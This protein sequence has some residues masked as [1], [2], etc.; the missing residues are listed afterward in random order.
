MAEPSGA[1]GGGAG[2]T[3]MGIDARLAGLLAYLLGLVSGLVIF[4]VEKEHQEVRYHA[5]Q[6]II[7][8]LAVLAVYIVLSAI[9]AIP[10]IGWAIALIV[11]PLVGI[12]AVVLWVYLLV[13][14][15]QLNH[16]RLPVTGQMAEQ[17]VRG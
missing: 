12:A 2:M 4:L 17:W 7:V 11:G 3:S 10:I 9:S 1:A 8:S 15:Y 13:Q 14:G 6:S 16:V 5:A